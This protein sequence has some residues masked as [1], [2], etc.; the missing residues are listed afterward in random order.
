MRTQPPGAMRSGT[1][2]LTDTEIDLYA[3]QIIVPGV[4][5]GGQLRL[6][7][8]PVYFPGSRADAKLGRRYA[9]AAGMPLVEDAHAATLVIVSLHDDEALETVIRYL[10]TSADSS[11]NSSAPQI[12]IVLYS[13]EHP[14]WP[15]IVRELDELQAARRTRTPTSTLPQAQHNAGAC[16]AAG[17]A[18]ALVLGWQAPG[19]PEV[20][21]SDTDTPPGSSRSSMPTRADG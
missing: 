20:H 2:S 17:T 7:S 11:K 15:R 5:A 4:G 19:I 6:L 21:D 1:A 9:A 12:P 14:P 13:A 10:E 16:A 18:M 3:R 8:S